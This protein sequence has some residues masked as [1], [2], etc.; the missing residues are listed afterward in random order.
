MTD[1]NATI[2]PREARK[3]PRLGYTQHFHAVQAKQAE[4]AAASPTRALVE[5]VVYKAIGLGC[6]W[7][8]YSHYEVAAKTTGRFDDWVAI[9]VA[10]AGLY[11]I[12]PGPLKALLATV[13]PFLPWGKKSNGAATT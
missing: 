12:M 13:T 3:T 1:P 8:G 2:G 11:F 10:V 4:R 6:L 9:A 5:S 7:W